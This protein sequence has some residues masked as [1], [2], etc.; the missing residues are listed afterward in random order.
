[1]S[2]MFNVGRE[3]WE[4]ETLAADFGVCGPYHE[5]ELYF[6]VA[7]KSSKSERRWW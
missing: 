2:D 6:Y 3:G 7:R 4:W 1:M 5:I